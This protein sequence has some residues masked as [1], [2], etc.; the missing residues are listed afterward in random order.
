MYVSDQSC[1]HDLSLDGSLN[2]LARQVGKVDS[3]GRWRGGKGGGGACV[4]REGNI[5]GW[6][7]SWVYLIDEEFSGPHMPGYD[8]FP[9]R[10]EGALIPGG[11]GGL[12]P[13][14]QFDAVEAPL[15]NANATTSLIAHW[16]QFIA[17]TSQHPIQS[18][19]LNDKPLVNGKPLEKLHNAHHKED[20]HLPR[21]RLKPD[22][23]QHHM[24]H[25]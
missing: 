25:H 12:V 3:I 1:W 9:Q 11:G 21:N 6:C 15:P 4:G 2:S 16:L 14:Q 20:A 7:I 10:C 5:S 22:L 24:R 8:G 13:Q 18:M 19:L 17:F 23:N